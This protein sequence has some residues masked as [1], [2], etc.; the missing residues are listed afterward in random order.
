M[1]T[2]LRV[3]LL[4]FP[5]RSF[6]FVG[7]ASYGTHE[8]ARFC[9]RHRTRLTLVSK[10]HPEANLF[11]PPGPYRG[12]GRP[13]VKGRALPKPCQVATTAALRA[14]SVGWYGGG[15]RVV[16]IAGGTGHGYKS[17]QGLIPIGW[18]F[19]RDRTGTHRDESFFS[20]DPAMDPVAM[21]AAS[22]GRWNLETT[23]Q[24]LRRHLG[25]ETTRSWCRRTVPRAAPGLFGLYAVVALLY[26]TLPESGRSGGVDWPGKTG[27][28][29]SDA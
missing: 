8:L 3:L 28:T 20:T 10:L 23:F 7:D 4:W 16:E 24:E 11:E 13:A 2:L 21:I 12:N 1:A 17:G 19:V 5:E 18:V 25:L 22:T 27:V 14:V 29:F 15:T 6:I 9:H 26:Q